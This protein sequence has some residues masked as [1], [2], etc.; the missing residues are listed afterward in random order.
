MKSLASQAGVSRDTVYRWL[1]GKVVPRPGKAKL[2][3]EWL[4]KRAAAAG[5]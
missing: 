2:I 3:E 1:K 5:R 4:N